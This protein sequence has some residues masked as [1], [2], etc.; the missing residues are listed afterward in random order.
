[1]YKYIKHRKKYH[2]VFSYGL[3][4]TGQFCT[5]FFL[6]QIIKQLFNLYGY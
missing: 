6:S 3:S 2:N 1:M 4:K 5:Y